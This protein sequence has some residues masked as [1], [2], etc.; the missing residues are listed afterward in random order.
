M[1]DMSDWS[2]TSCVLESFWVVPVEGAPEKDTESWDPTS[3]WRSRAPQNPER[4]TFQRGICS[5]DP[6]QGGQV[7]SRCHDPHEL[8]SQDRP[9]L[10]ELLSEEQLKML[11]ML[12]MR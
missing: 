1:N 2:R 4:L 8:L 6:G 9:F 10:K 11:G 7:M 3:P 12:K 5:C